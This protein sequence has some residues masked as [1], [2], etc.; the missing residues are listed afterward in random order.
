MRGQSANQT[1]DNLL[2]PC[3]PFCIR[4]WVILKHIVVYIQVALL[5]FCHH[6]HHLDHLDLSTNG[7]SVFVLLFDELIVDAE[8]VR[9]YSF[10]QFLNSLH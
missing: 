2:V 9:Y 7:F 3:D 10:R 5:H 8:I 6:F 1:H 4:S